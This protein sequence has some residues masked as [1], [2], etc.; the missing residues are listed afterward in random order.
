M[1]RMAKSNVIVDGVRG[2]SSPIE[3]AAVVP[4]KP[5]TK[6]IE[7]NFDGGGSCNLE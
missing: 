3:A 6:V 4:G 1:E 2:L 5:S 7:V